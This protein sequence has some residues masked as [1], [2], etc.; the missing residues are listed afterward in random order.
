MIRWFGALV[1]ALLPLPAFAQ[2]APP[3]D[4]RI[5]CAEWDFQTRKPARRPPPVQLNT[6]VAGPRGPEQVEVRQ[7][8]LK[9]NDGMYYPWGVRNAAGK[10]VVPYRFD[11]VMPTSP[12]GAVVS[13][14]ETGL[15]T[16]TDGEGF[17]PLALRT[18]RFRSL[19]DFANCSKAGE[20]VVI[21]WGYY[22]EEDKVKLAIFHGSEQ[23]KILEDASPPR[24][25]NRLM[26][27]PVRVPGGYAARITDLYGNPRSG[28]IGTVS[29]WH[30]SK[31]EIGDTCQLGFPDML[32]EG[33][34]LDRNPAQK[35]I[36]PIYFPIGLDGS[37]Y[38][39][40]QGALGIF[41]LRGRLD[42][43]VRTYTN[44]DEWEY[45]SDSWGL[46]YPDGQG[47][48][49]SVHL[50]K[51]LDA[52]SRATGSEPR[53]RSPVRD[54]QSGMFAAQNVRDGSWQLFHPGATTPLP[55]AGTFA[56]G[57]SALNSSL[58][59]IAANRAAVEVR[60]QAERQARLAAERAQYLQ[61]RQSKAGSLCQYL[62]PMRLTIEEVSYHAE[63][64]PR[65]F[66]AQDLA[67]AR[68]MGL[69]DDLAN[70]I[71]GAWRD[72]AAADYRAQLARELAR[73]DALRNPV[74][75][76]YVPGAWGDA[77]RNAGN[78]AVDN[79]NRSSE[80]WFDARRKSY[81]EEWQ[82]KQRAY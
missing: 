27:V 57:R 18:E 58:S 38:P 22:R 2:Q 26:F 40:P 31:P 15:G 70:A 60:I 19:G 65:T 56:D 28:T 46:V 51:P 66:I 42:Q 6:T 50:G 62:P 16:W 3:S 53:Y 35:D 61:F 12:S 75:R 63:Q 55:I 81:R 8:P 11:T 72:Q 69:T 73:E 78:V 33:P 4:P 37:F 54:P 82:R 77:I 43:V 14:R 34:S 67:K 45:F 23:P 13:S 76:P 21:L 71:Q 32:S 29:Y 41:P 17:K 36:G 48:A 24:R 52:I 10:V 59:Q 5:N 64:C 1:L 25:V 80:N 9:C 7:A 68:Q 44:D 30:A 20:G 47:W 39:M 49:F 74:P 79:I